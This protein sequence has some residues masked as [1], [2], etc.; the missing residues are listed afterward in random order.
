MVLAPLKESVNVTLSSEA[1]REANA[2]KGTPARR[3]RGKKTQ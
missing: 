3:V 2:G 1:T